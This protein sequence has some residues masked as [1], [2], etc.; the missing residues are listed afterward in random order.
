MLLLIPATALGAGEE[1]VVAVMRAAAA[2]LGALI[3]AGLLAHAGSAWKP[4]LGGAM[5]AMAVV[6]LF[7]SWF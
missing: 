2:C 3:P 5:G 6:W 7:E 4:A 1:T